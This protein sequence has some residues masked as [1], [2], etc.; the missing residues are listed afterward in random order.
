[1]PETPEAAPQKRAARLMLAAVVALGLLARLALALM[2]GDGRATCLPE[3]REYLAIGR[4]VADGN[5][6]VLPGQSGPAEQTAK[7]HPAPVA[8]AA[9]GRPKLARRMPGYPALVAAAE[10]MTSMPLRAVLLFQAA[11]GGLTLI[12]AA[13]AS[14]RLA[15][16]WA[17][18]VAV[19]LLAFDPYEVYFAALAVPVVPAGL[20]LVAAMA[21]GLKFIASVEARSRWAW[22]WAAGTGL[23]A[24][25]A[26]YF[27][28]WAAG[29]VVP[30]GVAAA[31]AGLRRR[32]L[33]GWALG[34]AVLLVCLAPW[35][36]RNTARL[37]API[38]TT[39][40]G[41]RLFEG[42]PMQCSCG[43][44]TRREAE[45][46]DE[47]GQDVFYLKSALGEMADAPAQWL[48][49][50]ALRVG[51]LWSLGPILEGGDA[52]IH[53][54]AGY[55]TLLPSATLALVGVWALRRRR[56]MAAWLLLAPLWL[57]VVHA[58]L[59]APPEERFEVMPAL[60]VLG[61]AGLMAL[62]G[63]QRQ[64]PTGVSG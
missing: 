33:A 64:A 21:L 54:A 51:R 40:T 23:A 20:A 28:A 1:M 8:A 31:L 44:P 19:A 9:A 11:C 36:I 43:F 48:K 47:V 32:L 30:V 29:L 45:G 61:G 55:T 16:L 49:L 12:I 3:S 52:V 13:W 2:M 58:V 39:L 35:M 56:A 15:G 59:A 14:W 4:S 26:A 60:A 41:E 10:R 34:T 46:L 7:E 53:P 42:T 50:A 17:G 57:T 5:G 22:V 62:V 25:A 63:R 24:A 37:G 38:L 18:L 6:F 27:D